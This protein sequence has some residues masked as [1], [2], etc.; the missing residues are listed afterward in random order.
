VLTAPYM[1]LGFVHMA[2]E[3]E[4]LNEIVGELIELT[5]ISLPISGHIYAPS[6]SP[7]LIFSYPFNSLILILNYAENNSLFF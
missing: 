5:S 4:W 6:I 3:G 7:I 2:Q 1:C